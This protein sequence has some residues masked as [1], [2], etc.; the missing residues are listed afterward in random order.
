MNNREIDLNGI[1]AKPLYRGLLINIFM[2]AIMIAFAYY[3]DHSKERTGM[4][5]SDTLNILFWALIILSVA[6]GAV[7]ILLRKRLSSMPMIRSK[8]TFAGD[9]ADRVL[10]MSLV[11][12][13]VTAAISLYGLAFYILGGTFD[14]FFLFVVISF[15]AFQF[16]RPRLGFIEKVVAAQEKLVSEGRFFQGKK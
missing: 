11:C 5:P 2:P 10:A 14:H 1:I 12:F 4:V 15:I 16:V 8:E 13:A 9:L 6:D 3:I 7:A